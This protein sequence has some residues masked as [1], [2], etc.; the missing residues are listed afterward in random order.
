[1]QYTEAVREWHGKAVHSQRA[2]RAS[3]VGIVV[4]SRC[5]D[6]SEGGSPAG[7]CACTCATTTESLRCEACDGVPGGWDE[8]IPWRAAATSAA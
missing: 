6:E 4:V 7:V 8:M 5:S 1:M 3:V 2:L